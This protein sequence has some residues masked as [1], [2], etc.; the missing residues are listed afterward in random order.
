MSCSQFDVK[1]YFLGEL[2]GSDRRL[3]EEHLKSCQECGEE[4]ER[5][6]MMRAA[7]VSLP[8]EELPRRIAFVSD[9]V[10][11]HGGW[12]R[13]WNSAPRLAF[14]SAALLSVAILVH[15]FVRPAPV[16]SP[17]VADTP[18][19]EARVE[20]Q[21]N[22]RVQAALEILVAESEARQ[23][24]KTAELVAAAEKKMDQER[25]EDL[26]MVEENFKVLQKKVNVFRTASNE[27]GSLR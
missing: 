23:A 25:R 3:A 10:F 7:L 13:W 9:K 2:T 19:L 15:A 8:D 4:L 17:A 1:A 12:A 16:I 22:K 26:L 21:I 6:G 24:Q 20:A 14:A 18:V 5:L 11:E 27:F